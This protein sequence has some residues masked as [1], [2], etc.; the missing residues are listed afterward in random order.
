[1]DKPTQETTNLSESFMAGMVNS[2]MPALYM[3]EVGPK[4]PTAA[5]VR[6][7]LRLKM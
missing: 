5:D 7:E 4:I 1:M 2:E 6:A 3:A